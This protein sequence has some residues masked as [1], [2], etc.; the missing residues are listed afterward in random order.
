[1]KEEDNNISSLQLKKLIP[2]S[3]I[4]S[5]V[6]DLNNLMNYIINGIEIINDNNG[7]DLKTKNILGNIKK[8]SKLASNILLQL[9]SAWSRPVNYKSNIRLNDTLKSLINS[10]NNNNVK[11]SFTPLRDSDKLLANKTELERA[12]LNLIINAQEAESSNIIISL[13][14]KVINADKYIIIK[15]KDDGKGI[16]EYHLHKLFEEGYS[17]KENGNARGFGLS[18]VKK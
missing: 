5:A 6:H 2:A 18:I 12:I 3:E 9:S 14:K 16:S 8:N 11:I 17:T 15:I 13:E 10:F 1:M 7:T 4:K